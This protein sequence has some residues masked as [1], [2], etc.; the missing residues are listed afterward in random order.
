M[1]TLRMRQP[2]GQQA[3]PSLHHPT[4]ETNDVNKQVL[5]LVKLP[6]VDILTFSGKIS[7][8]Q[9]FGEA[10]EINIHQR[11]LGSAGHKKSWI[12]CTSYIMIPVTERAGSGQDQRF[13]VARSELRPSP[14]ETA[15]AL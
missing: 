14:V 4:R 8:W 12:C 10:F 5:S 3:P 9:N 11:K 2:T 15:K 13:R 7:E 1:E 6:E